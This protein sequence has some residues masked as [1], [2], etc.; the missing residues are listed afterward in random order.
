VDEG[1][2]L[3][4]GDPT[5]MLLRGKASE[6]KLRLFLAACCRRIWDFLPD[7]SCRQAVLVAEQLADGKAGD[8]QRRAISKQVAEGLTGYYDNL[9]ASN[10]RFAVLSANE[11]TIGKKVHFP[12]VALALGYAA[13]QYGDVDSAAFK[14]ALQAE[15]QAE[16]SL[17]RCLFGNPFRPLAL[18]LAWLSWRDGLVRQL[19]KAAYD[20]RQLL[21]GHLHPDRLAVLA[22]ALEEAGCQDP[23]M[24]GHLR[25]PGAVHVRGCYVVD[26]LLAKE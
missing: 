2:W 3:T 24:L 13:S 20:E 17:V 19:A 4:C 5:P 8:R 12:N 15:K 6:R 10:A 23:D 9:I 22:D 14:D 1:E 18:D 7:E 16:A 25:Q 21:S 26:L 11:K